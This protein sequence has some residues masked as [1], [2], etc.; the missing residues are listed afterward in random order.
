MSGFPCPS[1]G[2][3]PDPGIEPVSPAL[4]A[5]S[6]PS[7]PQGRLR[8]HFFRPPACCADRLDSTTWS[9]S[10]NERPQGSSFRLQRTAGRAQPPAPPL[11]APGHPALKEGLVVLPACLTPYLS[12]G[13]AS[14][15]YLPHLTATCGGPRPRVSHSIQP[16][17]VSCV[18]PWLI[19]TLWSPVHRVLQAT[20]SEVSIHDTTV[21]FCQLSPRSL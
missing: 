6:L 12:G 3:L 7:E 11:P 15:P 9:S 17:M 14:G 16:L 18:G 20:C 19:S 2:D 13:P 5:D 10:S 1:L 8:G 4:Q 21:Y